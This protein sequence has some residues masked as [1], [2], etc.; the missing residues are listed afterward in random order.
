MKNEEQIDK[1]AV[2]RLLQLLFAES[3]Q[4]AFATYREKP[5]TAAAKDFRTWPCPGLADIDTF[6]DSVAEHSPKKAIAVVVGVFP[7][8]ADVA[9]KRDESECRAL[10]AI[11]IDI[12]EKDFA[13]LVPGATT[14]EEVVPEVKSRLN[15]H[16]IV[17]HLLIS[18]G[19]GL[20]VYVLVERVEFKD[21]AERTRFKQAWFKIA[22]LLGSTDRFDLSSIMRLP[23]T[24]NRKNGGSRQA[25][26]LEDDGD[27]P[28]YRIEDLDTNLAGLGDLPRHKHVS[29]DKVQAQR[30]AKTGG[31]APDQ[32]HAGTVD[33]WEV[34]IVDALLRPR[35]SVS[36]TSDRSGAD[37]SYGRKLLE[38]GFS[39]D[40]LRHELARSEKTKE[41]GSSYHELTVL[42]V[43]ESTIE[44]RTCL[45]SE[46]W[47]SFPSTSAALSYMRKELLSWFDEISTSRV[48]GSSLRLPLFRGIVAV[49]PG[50]GKT[51]GLRQVLDGSNGI[52]FSRIGIIG[53]FVNE[54]LLNEHALLTEYE[55]GSAT[56]DGYLLRDDS[57][58]AMR[59]LPRDLESLEARLPTEVRANWSKIKRKVTSPAAFFI[60]A[61]HPQ[62]IDERLRQARDGPNDA[63]EMLGDARAAEPI[64]M[65]D[66][67][68]AVGVAAD[69]REHPFAV[70]KFKGR[71][72]LCLAG[73]GKDKLAKAS[74]CERC[75]LFACRANGNHDKHN[76]STARAPRGARTFWREATV[77]LLATKAM[78]MHLLFKSSETNFNLV[79]ADEV[80]EFV[81]RTPS[82]RIV[83]TRRLAGRGTWTVD[84]VED[85]DKALVTL[86]GAPERKQQVKDIMRK[87]K[88]IS[89]RWKQQAIGLMKDVEIQKRSGGE[90]RV[91]MQE[92]LI[93]EADF[94]VLVSCA[95]DVEDCPDDGDVDALSPNASGLHRLLLRLRDFASDA[96]FAVILEHDLHK[97]KKT[98]E[99]TVTRPVNGWADLLN[100][101]DGGARSVLLLDATARIDPRY[102]LLGN[103]FAFEDYSTEREYPNTVI[104]LSPPPKPR[105]SAT[106]AK[107][108]V[109]RNEI[110]DRAV[111]IV[112]SYERH[113]GNLKD[114]GRS[115]KLLV[116]TE[117]KSEA[118]L[119]SALDDARGSQGSWD[120]EVTVDHFGNLRGR[121]DYEDYDAVYFEF[122]HRY[123]GIYY[124]GLQCLL[125][126]LDD[127]PGQ[128]TRQGKGDDESWDT[129][130]VRYRAMVADMYQDALRIGLRRDPSRA[131][132]VFVPT[133]D[134]NFVVR[135]MRAFRGAKLVANDGTTIIGCPEELPAGSAAPTTGSP[136]VVAGSSTAAAPP[137]PSASKAA[138]AT[139]AEDAMNVDDA[140]DESAEPDSTAPTQDEPP[141]LPRTRPGAACSS[142]SCAPAPTHG[143]EVVTPTIP[144]CK[145]APG[146]GR[147]GGAPNESH[148]PANDFDAATNAYESMF[149]DWTS[150]PTTPEE[151]AERRRRDEAAFAEHQARRSAY[152]PILLTLSAAIGPYERPHFQI[153]NALFDDK[154]PL[155]PTLLALYKEVPD[156]EGALTRDGAPPHVL[157]AIVPLLAADGLYLVPVSKHGRRV[158][159]DIVKI[160]PACPLNE[161]SLHDLRGLPVEQQA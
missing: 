81:Y 87:L 139:A 102:M 3:D 126:D 133:V 45:K 134:D 140:G 131:A 67:V 110:E 83:Y 74:T 65:P 97:T 89:D 14:I 50:L 52:G 2:K 71:P 46:A 58:G 107:G 30:A 41:K 78:E 150:P 85:L 105:A 119:Q 156:L 16:G 152:P 70:L 59:E 61:H 84:L 26:L 161:L 138:S 96:P 99:M 36:L 4:F 10:Q 8:A 69:R 137:S 12:D 77:G 147:A 90:H 34:V 25:S 18:S 37:S 27:A 68:R 33:P 91:C 53:K 55:W 109:K 153:P 29:A 135:L 11:A 149:A 143:T 159:V 44:S 127:F 92:P 5:A 117:K 141:P 76:T 82:I 160:A 63:E 13:N 120:V 154:H 136:S 48:D 158:V 19:Y 75:L 118:A 111:A 31:P 157:D 108:K 57:G 21:D 60:N 121:N 142:S 98:C 64:G 155:R 42:H 125:G 129:S 94:K 132:L 66:G 124:D 113:R 146:S 148:P 100:G 32:V 115:A 130:H 40:L 86:G 54:Q 72:D 1:S 38:L 88:G 128:W 22:S 79:I 24:F 35:S 39:V 122:A 80:P 23:G 101:S 106:L 151:T 51:R 73:F 116:L 112:D 20:H 9:L 49:P 103:E 123:P 95:S 17:P 93:S 56:P 7:V 28:R 145:A 15:E 104:V 47:I 43:V 62:H 144:A 114:L 6:L